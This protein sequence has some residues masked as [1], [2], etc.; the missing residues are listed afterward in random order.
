LYVFAILFR[1]RLVV[2]LLL[3]TYLHLV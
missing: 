2:S 3:H 1:P